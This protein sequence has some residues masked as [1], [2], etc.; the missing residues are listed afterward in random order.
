MRG[1]VSLNAPKWGNGDRSAALAVAGAEDL[2]HGVEIFADA[3]T[4]DT[5][6]RV[7][8]RS[9]QA[10]RVASPR[11]YSYYMALRPTDTG[12]LAAGILDGRA[13]TQ[14]LWLIDLARDRT[15][16]LRSTRGFTANPVWSADGARLA[17]NSGSASDDLSVL[18]DLERREVFLL[19]IATENTCWAPVARP[20]ADR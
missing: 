18:L 5:E 8:N 3:M 9:G 20:F 15:D 4:I 10:T 1:R 14:D 16:A 11:L 6:L 13:G 12:T 19:P 17:V 2:A 7:V